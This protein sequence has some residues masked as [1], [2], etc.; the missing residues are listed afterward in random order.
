MRLS[1]WKMSGAGNDFICLDNR[2]KKLRLSRKQIE[3]LCHR[4][5]GVG[6]DGLLVLEPA[7]TKTADFRMRY[8]NAD[9]GEAEMCGNG[10][11]CFARFVQRVTRTK[12]K[13][14]SFD[15]EAGLVLAEFFGEQVRV[16]L[17][18]PQGLQL[19]QRVKLST[20]VS[21]VHSL[22]TGVPHVVWFLPDVESIDLLKLG[23]ELRYHEVFQPKGTNVNFAQVLGSGKIRVR[24]YERGVEAETLACGTGVTAVAL[25]A[26]KVHG[27][28]S[29]V[30]VKVQ[31]GDTLSVY[32][33]DLGEG[34]AEVQLHGP[35]AFVY[36][37]EIDV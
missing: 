30:S 33:K 20:G 12:K 2:R 31:G 4:Q 28:R 37:G 10:A 3:G 14:I 11:R 35:A 19:N 17:T 29:P 9:G 25:I 1:F 34:W 7:R 5:F 23:A 8:Y 36:E 32:F 15:T 16:Q 27:F 13:K 22:N 18:A 21:A 26:A 24:T 6:A